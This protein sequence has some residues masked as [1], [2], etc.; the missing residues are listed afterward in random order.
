[1]IA[2]IL[3]RPA[4]NG[5]QHEIVILVLIVRLHQTMQIYL[6][7]CIFLIRDNTN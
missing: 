5:L 3:Y 4:D 7:C 2:A 6:D 1:M